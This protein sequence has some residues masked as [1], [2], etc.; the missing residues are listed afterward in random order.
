[1]EKIVAAAVV[2]A[3]DKTNEPTLQ[4]LEGGPSAVSVE[5]PTE[6][7]MESLKEETETTSPSFLS[8]DQTRSVGT[9]DI[10]QPKTSEELA[11]ELTFSE[12]ILEQIVA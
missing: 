7:A 8:S 5:V 4:V 6:V 11:K 10:L 12:A 2:T 9:E 3:K 1:M